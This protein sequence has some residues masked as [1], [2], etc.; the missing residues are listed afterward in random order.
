MRKALI[1]GIN[2]YPNCPLKGGHVAFDADGDL[3][4][5]IYAVRN[6][7]KLRSVGRNLQ[8]SQGGRS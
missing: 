8:P 1:V 3:I 4:K 5:T 6:P 2:G 7:E